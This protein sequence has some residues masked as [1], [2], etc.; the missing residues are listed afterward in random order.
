MSATKAKDRGHP[1]GEDGGHSSSQVIS[2]TLKIGDC[3]VDTHT[4]KLFSISYLTL[5]LNDILRTEYKPKS[6]SV[7]TLLSIPALVSSLLCFD[8]HFLRKTF[9]EIIILSNSLTQDTPF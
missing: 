3:P 6:L 9:S 7:Q 5:I 2:M 4:S 1:S 8:L